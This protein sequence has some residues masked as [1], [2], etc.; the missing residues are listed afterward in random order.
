MKSLFPRRMT[1]LLLTLVL[2]F[3]LV[4]P[5]AAD[6]PD[7][8]ED[9]DNPDNPP[10]IQ[11]I[12]LNRN[13]LSLKVGENDQTITATITPAGVPADS[14]EVEWSSDT[15][16]V[17]TVSGN[18]LTATVHAVSAGYAKITAYIKDDPSVASV[19]CDVTVTLPPPTVKNITISPNEVDMTIGDRYTLRSE[20]T[21][22]SGTYPGVVSWFSGDDQVAV[23]SGG[24]VEARGAGTTIIT[25]KASTTTADEKSAICKVVVSEKPQVTTISL[26][27]SQYPASGTFNPGQV[28]DLTATVNNSNVAL[29][30]SISPQTGVIEFVQNPGSS[31]SASIRAVGAGRATITVT[32]SDNKSAQCAVTVTEIDPSK[33]TSVTISRPDT[34]YVDQNGTLTL[35]AA[36]TPGTAETTLRWYSDNSKVAAVALSPDNPRQAIVTGVS[37]GTVKITVTTDD[38]RYSDSIQLEVSGVTLEKSTL[39]LFVNKSETLVY[40][41]YG[42]VKSTIPT[43]RAVNPSIADA[44]TA[45]RVTGHYPGTTD[46]E[47]TAGKYTATC[48][49]TVTEDLA[50]AI[51]RNMGSK[52]SFSFADIL[53]DLNQRCQSKTGSALNE[54]Y[55]LQVSTKNGILYYGY[56]TPE[57]PGH[58]V[59]GTERYYV[60]P[61]QGQ[62]PIRDITFVPSSGYTGTAVIDYTGV[63]AEGVTF[64]G[65]IRITMTSTGDVTYSTASNQPLAFSAGDFSAVCQSKNGK[66]LSYVTFEQPASS[67]GTLYYNYSPT[68]Q[69]SQKVSSTTKYYASSSPSISTITFVPAENYIGPVNVTYRCTDSAGATFIGNVAITVFS[70]TGSGTGDV[71]YFTGTGERVTLNAADFQDIAQKLT[72]KNLDYIQFGSL[73][74]TANGVLYYNYTNVNSARVTTT[75]RYYRTSSNLRISYITFVPASNYIGTISVP[76]TGYT[77]TGGTFHGNLVIRVGDEISGTIHYT[78]PV[79]QPVTF[80]VTDFNNACQSANNAAL[81]RV[82]FT[83]PAS[84]SG[85]LYYNYISASATGTRIASSESYY[86]SGSP[87]LS[88]V[89]FVPANNYNGSVSIP[90]SGYD[91]NGGVFSGTVR[92]TVGSGQRDETVAYSTVT[93]GVVHFNAADFNNACRTITGETLDYLRFT[94]PS[95]TYGTLYYKYASAGSTGTAVNSSTKYYR[96]A[97]SGSSNRLLSDVTFVASA[98]AG[99]TS[100]R[101]NGTTANGNT[102][103]GKIEITVNSPTTNVILYTGSSTPI[104]FRASDF[105]TACQAALGNP[106]S[107]I[108]FTSLPSSGLLSSGYVSPTQTGTAVTTSTRYYLSGSPEINQ[109]SFRPKAETQGTITI[110]FTGYDT[111]GRSFTNTVQISLSNSYATTPFTDVATGWDWAKPSIEFLRQSG[112]TNGYGNNRYGPGRQISRAEFTL[113]ICRAFQFQTNTGTA[114]FPDVPATSVYASAIAAARNLGIVQGENGLFKP[115]NPITRQSAMT[116][117]CRAIQAAGQSLPTAP[118]TILSAFSDEAQVSAFARSSVASLIQMG[119]VRGTAD[120][121]INPRAAISRAEMAVILHRVLTR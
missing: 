98:R 5:A 33:A 14:Y 113:M 75:N 116:M 28:F 100:I 93:N 19:T 115:N 92:I 13:T 71:E 108:Q 48:T 83:L 68:G 40:H 3:S 54:I 9:V 26:D 49:V 10:A 7:D 16:E 67:M 82:S 63:S 34:E 15:E 77:T 45:G 86:R 114:S 110:P 31:K 70:P 96:T 104:S 55:G 21:M 119:A 57:S 37:P 51:E 56:N 74:N 8:G 84:S 35:T 41:L 47:I 18:G 52:T 64:I 60:T 62:M 65:T 11:S 73:P 76:F 12:S 58:G 120:M 101:Y 89:T 66:A 106:L 44:S 25:A 94:L 27:K 61:G 38:G 95:S 81:N 121:R 4:V 90:F 79:N 109:I 6:D 78:T 72:G 53:T 22:T 23:V 112:I 117:I 46:I 2:A 99:T 87:S 32:T 39:N 80:S 29:S 118:T 102:F 107:Y 1:S 103:T 42:S 50:Q 91:V 85:T 43:W 20:V 30:W 105:Q 17:A 24:V 69:Y 88:S 59:G 111:S 36:V 97:S